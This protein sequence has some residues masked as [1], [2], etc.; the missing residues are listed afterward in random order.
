MTA[1]LGKEA[2]IS[3]VINALLSLAFFLAM[4]RGEGAMLGFD[5]LAIDFLPQSIAVSLMSALVPALVT[6]GRWMKAGVVA[7]PAL[8]SVVLRAALFALGGAVLG[9]LLALAS[10]GGPALPWSA[11]L[12]MKLLYGGLLGAIITTMMLRRMM[13]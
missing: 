11:A 4:F 9:G 6:R 3:F 13:R 8:R 1:S 12:A 2:A 7:V 5:Q 10:R